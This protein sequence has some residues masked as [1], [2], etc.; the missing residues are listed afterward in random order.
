MAVMGVKGSVKAF[1][2]FYLWSAA[3]PFSPLTS[4]DS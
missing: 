2:Y 1:T 3:N 4:D